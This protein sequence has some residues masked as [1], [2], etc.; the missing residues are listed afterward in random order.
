MNTFYFSIL[1]AIFPGESGLAHTRTSPFW[2]STQV[3]HAGS[4]GD[5]C[6]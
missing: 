1:A 2:I 6:N 3:P 5:N 4:A